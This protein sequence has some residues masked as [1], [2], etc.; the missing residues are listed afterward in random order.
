MNSKVKFPLHSFIFYA[1]QLHRTFRVDVTFDKRWLRFSNDPLES[2]QFMILSKL[3]IHLDKITKNIYNL[4]ILF[5]STIPCKHKEHTGARSRLHRS[6]LRSYVSVFFGRGPQC[7]HV[8]QTSCSHRRIKRRKQTEP[9]AL[10]PTATVRVMDAV[11]R[12]KR[13]A[14]ARSGSRRLTMDRGDVTSDRS[15]SSAANA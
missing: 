7:Q 12:Y 6:P 2:I 9:R 15:Q 3:Y 4:N 5:S 14:Y 10:S 11:W 8:T 1:S 13:R